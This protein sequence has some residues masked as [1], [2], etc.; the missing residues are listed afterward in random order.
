MT[1][2]IKCGLSAPHKS[3]RNSRNSLATA[4]TVAGELSTVAKGG[5]QQPCNSRPRNSRNSPQHPLQQGCNSPQQSPE[6]S[7]QQPQQPPK[8]WRNCCAPPS[9]PRAR[10]PEHPAKQPNGPAFG[11]RA[12]SGCS[13]LTTVTSDHRGQQPIHNSPSPNSNQPMDST[14]HKQAAGGRG[15][16]SS[17][18]PSLEYLFHHF[19]RSPAD[20]IQA[21]Q[22]ESP[23]RLSGP[24]APAP[25]RARRRTSGLTRGL[26]GHARIASP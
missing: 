6:P 5:P 9:R 11:S 12:R 1:T 24:A 26:A 20:G 16:S 18:R 3:T 13:G 15:D 17:F 10:I 22:R 4:A 21:W 25:R 2:T 8:G 14:Q 19:S 7:P 23:M